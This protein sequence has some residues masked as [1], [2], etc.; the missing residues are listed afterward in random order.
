[1]NYRTLFLFLCLASMRSVYCV[2]GKNFFMF[3]PSF[4]FNDPERRV[5]LDRDD[6]KVLLDITVFGGKICQSQEWATYFLPV[7]KSC[8]RIT[9]DG[10]PNFH[11]TDVTAG[12]MDIVTVPLRDKTA[13]GI[14]DEIGNMTYDSV[15][16]FCPKCTE[17]GVGL[18]FKYQLPEQCWFSLATSV[19][20]V[21]N[22]LNI[23][24]N[25]LDAGGA[26]PDSGFGYKSLYAFINSGCST[27]NYGKFCGGCIKKTGVPE[28]E[29]TLGHDHEHA[30]VGKTSGFLG[31]IIPTGSAVCQKYLFA[32][33]IGNGKHVG[34]FG[35]VQ[36]E[37][38]LAQGNDITISLVPSGLIRYLAPRQE[39]RSFDLKGRPWSRYMWVWLNND[40]LGDP[41]VGTNVA[42][43]LQRMV[44]LVNYSTLCVDVN[45]NWS[46]DVNLGLQFERERTKFELGYHGYARE[47]EDICFCG[48][49]MADGLGLQ[50]FTGYLNKWED[51]DHLPVTRS[52]ASINAPVFSANSSLA[53]YASYT[54]GL[55]N[56]TY[57]PVTLDSLDLDSARTPAAFAQTIYVLLSHQF[58]T[59]KIPVAL[60]VGGSY[61]FA[62]N[63]S[64]PCGWKA[65]GALTFAF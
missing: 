8:I 42:S 57:I 51:N 25:I 37:Y 65:W 20:Q 21:R 17:V 4:E 61:T 39:Q 27:W 5:T 36:G 45:P 13:R 52:F 49:N 38:T 18:V 33:L 2:Y 26:G 62:S 19:V 30:D 54:A 11:G 1:M 9:E 22:K 7:D 43:A 46:V 56:A 40:A 32:P 53:D 3:K 58:D 24:E 14:Q 47:A 35:G 59:K 63:N 31:L 64:Y 60:R 55:T 12:F 16:N 15:V 50:A 23:C 6:K 28:I 10:S 44:P 48:A 34:L 29:I 41:A